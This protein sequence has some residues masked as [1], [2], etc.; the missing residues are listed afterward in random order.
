MMNRPLSIP[1]DPLPEPPPVIAATLIPAVQPPPMEVTAI[2]RLQAA[3]RFGY[4]VA[5]ADG[6]VAAS[7]RK[8]IRTF[9][10][11]RYIREPELAG[12]LDFVIGDVEKEIPSL[13]DA[14]SDVRRAI[15]S[16][17]WPE[18]Y[19]FAV[20]IADAA[21]ERNTREIECLARI[22]EELGIGVQPAMPK[23]AAPVVTK[24]PETEEALNE[25][26]CRVALE[27]A[28]AM[29]LNVDLIRRQY[30]LLSDRFAPEKFASHGAEFVKMASEKRLLVERAARHLLA[31]YN[32][33]QEPPA[34]APVTDM[35]HNPD[36]D[37]V[38]GG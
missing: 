5:K 25:P 21:G 35:R 38:F 32:E 29:P 17:A 30:R 6:R 19:Q 34:A 14:M 37:E 26:A 8:Q 1:D 33:P 22:A 10:E 23:Q 12:A 20:S 36:L 4:A 27:I 28:P 16:D 24:S 15:A 7:E 11:R 13:H 31:E 3:T 18:L 9:L 2:E